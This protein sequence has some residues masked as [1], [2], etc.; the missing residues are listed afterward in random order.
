MIE[1]CNFKDK[2]AKHCF[3]TNTVCPGKEKCVLYMT[4]FL[5]NK[6]DFN[7][8][9]PELRNV[10]PLSFK[11]FQENCG[12]NKLPDGVTGVTCGKYKR[13]CNRDNCKDFVELDQKKEVEDGCQHSF[14]S[15]GL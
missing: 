15:P 9:P 3:I 12:N 7:T 10:P 6:V 14:D 2:Q 5:M 8:E 1:D 4:Y 11:Q 13:I